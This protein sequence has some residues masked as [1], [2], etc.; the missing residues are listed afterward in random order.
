MPVDLDEPPTLTRARAFFAAR[1]VPDFQ[2]TTGA[3]HGWRNRARLAAR[4]VPDGSGR[5]SGK[6]VALGL[7]A[8]G[9]HDLVEIPDCVVHHP[10][11]NAAAAMVAEAAARVGVRAYDE[12]DGTGELRYVQLTA[13]GAA[14]A[15]GRATSA[16]HDALASVQVALVWNVP[17]TPVGNEYVDR[18]EDEDKVPERARLLAEEL[19]RMGGSGIPLDGRSSDNLSLDDDHHIRAAQPISGKSGSS[20]VP[21]QHIGDSGRG[22]FSAEVSDAPLVHSVWVNFND[23]RA[24]DIVGEEWAHVVGPRWQWSRHGDAD[25][26]YV[27]GSFMQSNTGSYNHL[28]E[29]LRRH[30]PRG[31]AVSELYAGAGAIG[32][33]IAAADGGVQSL[34]ITVSDVSHGG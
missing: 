7:F 17:A 21:V 15:P 8:R 20:A 18:N 26:C 28:L 24:N 19:W 13:V 32:L 23:S 4:S 3:V 27:P 31:A 33:S 16:D 25:V 22:Y 6:S 29:A 1:G 11:I 12:L 14:E 5:R 30:V 10:R 34:E 9:T 2:G